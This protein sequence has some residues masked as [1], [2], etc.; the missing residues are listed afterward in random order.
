LKIPS[1]DPSKVPPDEIRNYDHD[2][3]E[4]SVEEEVTL[5]LKKLPLILVGQLIVF[6]M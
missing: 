1:S 2:L 6:L 3:S 4:S 5:I